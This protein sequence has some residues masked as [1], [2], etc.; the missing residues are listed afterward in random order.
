MT[1]GPNL[2]EIRLSKIDGSNRDDHYYLTPDDECYYL[3]EYTSH[4]DFTVGAANN[5]IS[6]L[7]KPVDRKGRPEYHYKTAAIQECA[8]YLA[9]TLNDK[10]LEAATLVPV[11]PS[12]DRQKSSLR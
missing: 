4:K 12:K 2:A 8:R 10:W 1:F 3:F 11:P 5:L 9:A 6:N 7:K